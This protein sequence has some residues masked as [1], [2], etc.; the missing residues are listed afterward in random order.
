MILN[1]A[2]PR[3]LD[4]IEKANTPKEKQ[5]VEDNIWPDDEDILEDEFIFEPIFVEKYID[6]KDTTAEIET[7]NHII[8]L[9]L[10][11]ERYFHSDLFDDSNVKYILNNDS[12]YIE[13]SYVVDPFNEWSLNE[14]SPINFKTEDDVK[15]FLINIGIKVL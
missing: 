13:F 7:R 14:Y 12:F 3:L 9:Y 15:N 2:K 4:A 5:E 1:N 8:Y 11:N 10:F 6:T